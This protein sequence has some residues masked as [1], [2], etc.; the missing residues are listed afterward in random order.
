MIFYHK[1][2]DL[3]VIETGMNCNFHNINWVCLQLGKSRWRVLM[4]GIIS[5]LVDL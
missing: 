3:F 5:C 4:E 1:C 2:Q